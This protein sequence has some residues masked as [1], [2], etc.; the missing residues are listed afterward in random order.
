MVGHVILGYLVG[1]V[2]QGVMS[3]VG[4]VES[5]GHGS[6][7]VLQGSVGVSLGV[8]TH[9]HSEFCAGGDACRICVGCSDVK[10]KV[11]GAAE[12]SVRCS[13]GVG[14][15]EAAE[16]ACQSESAEESDMAL[17]HSNTSVVSRG[18]VDVKW[19]QSGAEVQNVAHGESITGHGFKTGNVLVVSHDC[20][21]NIHI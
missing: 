7:D 19:G 16:I 3:G 9:G 8:D 14:N 5:E 20:K 4:T 13:A 10:V 11:C 15:A 6:V 2:D 1:E 12:A 21:S 18:F 17:I